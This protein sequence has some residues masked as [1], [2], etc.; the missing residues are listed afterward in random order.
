MTRAGKNN[1]KSK[2]RSSAPAGASQTSP[3]GGAYCTFRCPHS[4]FPPADAA[5]ICRTMAAV[6]CKKLKT[7][8]DKNTPCRWKQSSR[9]KWG[10]SQ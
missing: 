9:K 7:L 10:K 4:D 8:V 6:Y 3:D 1:P 2:A 5:G